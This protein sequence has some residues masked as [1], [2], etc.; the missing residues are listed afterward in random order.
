MIADDAIISGANPIP[1]VEGP[2]AG[3]RRTAGRRVRAC[4]P[5]RDKEARTATFTTTHMRWRGV[6]T[7]QAAVRSVKSGQQKTRGDH[8]ARA[9]QF[10]R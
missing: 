8:L 7:W 10:F 6:L 4:R 3:A 2:R 5:I 1:P 9:L